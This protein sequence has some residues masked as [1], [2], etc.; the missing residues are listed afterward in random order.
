MVET[1][2]NR[3]EHDLIHKRIEE[4]LGQIKGYRLKE[5]LEIIG[6]LKQFSQGYQ[7]RKIENVNNWVKELMDRDVQIIGTNATYPGDF[8]WRSGHEAAIEM[9]ANDWKNFGKVNFFFEHSEINID[10]NTSWVTF[11]ATA[12]RFTQEDQNRSYE[13]SKKRSLSRIKSY[14]ELEKPS[15]LLLYQIINDACSVLYQYEQSELFV[16]PFR[17]S[18][19]L[20]KKNKKWLIKQIHFSWPGRG[21]PVVRLTNE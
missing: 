15:S 13:A 21:F 8:E 19:S 6:V 2:S 20:L 4:K 17:V 14:T 18:L 16:W 9:F 3:E 5:E 11:F 12:T 10:E 1:I 7:E